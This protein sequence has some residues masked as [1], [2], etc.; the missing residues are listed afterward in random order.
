MTC[1]A[2]E[3]LTYFFLN[4][5]AFSV[6]FIFIFTYFHYLSQ[7]FFQPATGKYVRYYLSY[8]IWIFSI[9]FRSVFKAERKLAPQSSE[10][11]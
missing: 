2:V 1:A 4:I 5:S 3:Y 6:Y 7:Q 8:I 11:C 10:A 9:Q